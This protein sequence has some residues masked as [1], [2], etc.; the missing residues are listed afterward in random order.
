M[1]KRCKLYYVVFSIISVIIIGYFAVWWFRPMHVPHNFGGLLHGFDVI[2]FLL[3]SY[4]I[5][6]PISMEVLAWVIAGNIKENPKPRLASGAK[7]AFITNFVPAS[8]S[9]ELLKKTLPAMVAAHYEHDT[10]LLDEGDDEAVRALCASLG[11]KHYTRYGRAHYNLPEGKFAAKTKGGNHNSWYDV[12]G[13]SYDFVAQ[14]DTD[15]IPRQDFLTKTL[16]YFDDPHVAFVGTP[17]I[18]G[19]VGTSLIARG[20]AEQ[21]YSFYGPVLRGLCGMNMTLLI[22]ANHVIRVAALAREDYYSAHIT[23]DLLTG[24]KFHAKGWKSV[25]VHEALAVGEGPSTWKSYFTQQMRWAYGCIHIL[26]HHSPRLFRQM[27]LQ[28]KL[29][30]FFLQQHYFSGLAMVLGMLGIL[31]YFLGGIDTAT[32]QMQPF[33]SSYVPA[34]VVCGLM[35]LWL[36]RFNILPEKEKGIMLAGK[37]ISMAAWPI[38]F[39]A[40]IRVVRGK[41]LVYKVTPKGKTYRFN[42]DLRLFEPHL[43]ITTGAL[44]GIFSSFFSH[45]Q[46][47]IMLMWAASNAFCMGLLP[48]VEDIYTMSVSTRRR[49]HVLLQRLRLKRPASLAATEID[50]LP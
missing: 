37:I 47:W 20:A 50:P 28:K 1:N 23:E 34:I 27:S 45:R 38:F 36:Q 17:Q 9:I 29:Y 35:G 41:H 4:V 24:M 7:V 40:F 25:Y 18:Y 15:F 11:V 3:V 5:W 13:H 49:W 2:L 43:I 12:C 48:F 22:G 6:H 16:G 31:L 14:I 19:N 42:R 30:Y 33:L 8:E 44:T 32:L 10:W 21:T 26:F 46:S 39:L